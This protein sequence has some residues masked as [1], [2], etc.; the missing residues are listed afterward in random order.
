MSD[1][2]ELSVWELYRTGALV[3]DRVRKKAAEIIRAEYA[4]T[5]AAKDARIAELEAEVAHRAK[6]SANIMK[7]DGKNINEFYAD[8]SATPGSSG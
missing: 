7:H 3:S 5:L 2:A 1:P 4:A 8:E 6:L